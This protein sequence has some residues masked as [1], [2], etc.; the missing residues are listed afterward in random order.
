MFTPVSSFHLSL[1]FYLLKTTGL[2]DVPFNVIGTR[3]AKANLSERPPKILLIF[4]SHDLFL[5][6][7]VLTL[8][9]AF[10]SPY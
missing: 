1:I 7:I 4:L 8:L 9:L 2:S 10:V 3:A 5:S 6:L